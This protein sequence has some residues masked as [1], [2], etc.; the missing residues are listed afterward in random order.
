MNEEIL[1]VLGQKLREKRFLHTLGVAECAKKLA[2]KYGAD[3]EK[4][5]TAGLLHDIGHMKYPEHE[6]QS[7]TLHGGFERLC[8]EQHPTYGYQILQNKNIVLRSNISQKINYPKRDL[9]S[10]SGSFVLV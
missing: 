10:S 1:K 9:F 6:T 8:H 7:F 3:P 5:Y 2:F 4:A